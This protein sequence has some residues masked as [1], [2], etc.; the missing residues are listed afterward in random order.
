MIRLAC[1][2][3]LVRW[4]DQLVRY[5][6]GIDDDWGFVVEFENANDWVGLSGGVQAASFLNDENL[7]VS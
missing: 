7:G 3:E 2:D 6:L 5:R 1:D 4:R